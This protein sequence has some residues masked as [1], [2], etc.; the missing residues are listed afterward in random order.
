MEEK[1][2][3]ME[4]KRHM[5]STIKSILGHADALDR[6]LMVLG[7][8][9]AVGDG[10][11]TPFLLLLSSRLMNN[12]GN[13]PSLDPHRFTDVINKVI[14]YP[15]SEGDETISTVCHFMIKNNEGNL[16]FM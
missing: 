9:G 15:R 10:M 7:F 1:E 5:I 8:V 13:S 16:S 12:I 6:W 11:S 3:R 14:L 2:I 4:R